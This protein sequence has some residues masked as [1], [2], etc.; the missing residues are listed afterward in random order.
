MKLRNFIL[1]IDIINGNAQFQIMC[2]TDDNDGATRPQQNIY[3]I[4]LT[5]NNVF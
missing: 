1:C 3:W 5:Q 2:I 4:N